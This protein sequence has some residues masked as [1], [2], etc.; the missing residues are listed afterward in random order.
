MKLKAFSVFVILCVL[1]VAQAAAPKQR[2]EF[3]SL[4]AR[5]SEQAGF[6]DS[7]N[8]I[9]NETSY[10]H[11][12]GKLSELKFVKVLE[13]RG[14]SPP[15]S[16]RIRQSPQDLSNRAMVFCSRSICRRF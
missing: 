12:F 14:W 7:D 9:S 8:L 10:Q 3:A 11:V 16:L 4:S 2:K 13:R 6:F 15:F 1:T 5:L